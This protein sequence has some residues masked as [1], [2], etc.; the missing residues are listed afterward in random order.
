MPSSEYVRPAAAAPDDVPAAPGVPAPVVPAAPGD[1][2]LDPLLI[3]ASVRMN[4][5]VPDDADAP[6]AP[7]VL[8][9]VPLAAPPRSRH[10][11]HVIVWA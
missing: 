11:V 5:A 10:P 8:L 7:G 3:V 2:E 9:G 4:D 1:D 6:G